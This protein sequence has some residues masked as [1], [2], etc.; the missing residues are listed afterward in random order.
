MI[1]ITF[2]DGKVRQY[3]PG[4]TALEV[5]RSISEGLAQKVLSAKVNGEVWDATR[6]IADGEGATHTELLGSENLPTLDRHQRVERTAKITGAAGTKERAPRRT[7]VLG[8]L[9][10]RMD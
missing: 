8:V 6:P 4:T 1:N 9:L 5:A 2:P 10:I 3:E 7:P